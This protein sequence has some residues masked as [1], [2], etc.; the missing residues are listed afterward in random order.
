MSSLFQQHHPALNKA[1][2]AIRERTFYA[3]YPEH[4]KA[5][6]PDAPAQ[7]QQAFDNQLNH[8]F[9]QLLQTG[10]TAQVGEEESPYWGTPLGISY[11]AAPVE[12]LVSNAKTA[13]AT[14]RKAG[15]K[16]R[17]GILIESLERVKNRFF[18]IAW[19]TQHTTGQ[20]FIMS[21]QA[22][23]PHAADR[24]METIALGYMELSRFPHSLRWEK[25][26]GGGAFITLDKTFTP[27]PKGVSMVI[28][29][30]TFPTWNTVPGLYAS[31]ITGNTAMVKPHP[32][33]I[34]PI[35]I[36]VAEI[37]KVLHE[38]GFDPNTVQL[39]PDTTQHLIT[40]ELAEHPDVKIIDYTGSSL[41]GNYIETLQSKGKTVFTEKAG[42]NSV[43]IDS[44][45]DIRQVMRNLAFSV[46]LY[47]GQM[48][49]APQNIF[50]PETGVP[51]ADGPIPYDTVV[52]V[53]KNEVAALALNPK[54]GAGTLGAIQNPATL[55]RAQNA[56]KLG[57]T[58]LLE[59]PPVKNP[60]F[61]NARVCA[62][63]IIEV[64]AK[65][66]DLYEREFF[67]P[68]VLVI[69]T[70]NTQQSL[71]LAQ[72][73]A[74]HH[75]AITCGVYCADEKLAQHITDEMNSV[76][77]PVSLN[78]TGFIWVNQHAAFSDFHVTGGNPAGNAS[79]TDALFINKRFV[80]VGNRINM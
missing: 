77:V 80:W 40:K 11:P 25:P 58:V 39:A 41:F 76:F 53:L 63:T 47:S 74:M 46:S 29:C 79:F 49:T 66:A 22:S 57:G 32:K 69:K 26:A 72:N 37:Q 24:A 67:G 10:A 65:D 33:A 30:S 78:F 38:N 31:L 15:I 20:S 14:W 2:E 34:L 4:P 5:Y 6:G 48:C 13:L 18:E 36:F 60:E 3:H 23:G 73:M 56:G 1:I 54:M 21:F 7:G 75:G 42:V 12:T 45:Q 19:A 27:V 9:T 70:R 43:I 59:S 64:D 50:I 28:G 16:E 52:D 35:A 55:E 68:I 17:T 44:V 8:P 61:E 51:S 62:P 71:S